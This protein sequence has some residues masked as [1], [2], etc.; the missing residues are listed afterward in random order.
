M[1]N[2]D[3]LV[4]RHDEDLPT[5]SSEQI[6]TTPGE[7]SD[8]EENENEN[9]FFHNPNALE[10]EDEDDLVVTT[11]ASSSNVPVAGQMG[12]TRI[13]GGGGNDGV[14]AN[15]AAK[16]DVPKAEELPPSYA[17][18]ID[19]EHEE[20]PSYY[21]TILVNTAPSVSIED[22]V[23]LI[24]GMPVG[25]FFSFF[26]SMIVTL[27]FDFLGY[28][29]AMLMSQTHSGLYGAKCG[30]GVLLLRHGVFIETQVRQRLSEDKEMDEEA[31]GSLDI[32]NFLAYISMFAGFWL[33]VKSN[34]DYIRVRKLEGVMRT[35]PAHVV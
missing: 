16:P 13:G 12:T 30:L 23:L 7:A 28:L 17:D 11:A 26:A 3:I 33:V 15:M 29:I 21:E 5:Y 31:R 32:Y 14:F 9:V 10:M 24:E 27:S 8:D 22:D 25:N 35:R 2:N 34:L 19:M 6:P 1:D 20:I 18:V 4:V